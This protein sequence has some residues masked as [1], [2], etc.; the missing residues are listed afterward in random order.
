MGRKGYRGVSEALRTATA[1]IATYRIV[2]QTKKTSASTS[3]D[4]VA[5]EAMVLISEIELELN[6]VVQ[7]GGILSL[8]EGR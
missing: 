5:L 1:P 2:P 7:D 3:R 4:N 8:E 6:A